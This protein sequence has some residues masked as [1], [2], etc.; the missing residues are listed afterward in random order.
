MDEKIWVCVALVIEVILCSTDSL[1]VKL[2][3]AVDSYLVYILCPLLSPWDPTIYLTLKGIHSKMSAHVSKQRYC[4]CS[5]CAY[6]TE[7]TGC[8]QL[9][10]SAVNIINVESGFS[11]Y[12]ST[13]L[14]M[15]CLEGNMGCALGTCSL[16]DYGWALAVPLLQCLVRLPSHRG[17]GRSSSGQNFLPLHPTAVAIQGPPAAASC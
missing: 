4:I 2:F 15:V 12:F 14:I 1:T 5:L 8:S 7:K 17:N 10:F 3:H 9:P 11:I 13:F 16:W 6:S